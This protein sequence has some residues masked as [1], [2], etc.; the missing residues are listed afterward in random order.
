[1]TW[2]LS[3]QVRRKGGQPDSVGWV[4]H[5]Q[6]WIQEFLVGGYELTKELTK[7]FT[8]LKR[9]RL[10]QAHFFFFILA[11]PLLLRYIAY[12]VYINSIKSKYQSNQ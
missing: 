10:S 2:L 4:R 8:I 1:M 3:V 12:T 9:P 11:L 5:G 7:Y 6:G